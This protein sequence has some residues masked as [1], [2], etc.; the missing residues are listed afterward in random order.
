MTNKELENLARELVL[1]GL[2]AR[3]IHEAAL[4]YLTE[5]ELSQLWSIPRKNIYEFVTNCLDRFACKPP[6]LDLGCGRRSYKPEIT[7]RFG[8]DTL[9]IALDHYFPDDKTNPK[10]LPNL[11]ADACYLPLPSSSINTVI[12]TELLEHIENDNVV[13]AEISR[14]TEKNGLLIL[15]LPG[16]HIPKHDKPPYQI[17]HRR[18]RKEN[19]NNLL[20]THGFDILY[21]ENK[22]LFGLEINLFAVGQ[23]VR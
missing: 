4:E 2:N 13:M 5:E 17:D 14:V 7:E 10:R 19:L 6:F 9:F 18:Y 15:T 12:C 23:K 21:F 3:Q 16:A 1:K 20:S 22:S 8:V 11:L